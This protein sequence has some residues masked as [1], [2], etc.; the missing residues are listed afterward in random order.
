MPH[1]AIV[2]GTRKVLHFYER[3]DVTMLF[4]LSADQGEVENI[5][6]ERPNEHKKLHNEMMGYFKQ[7][8]ARIP[9]VNPDYDPEFYQQT[10]EYAQRMA[11][12]P[13]EGR[14]ALDDDEL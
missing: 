11:W 8:D 2:S 9:K 10:K 12:G 7:V 14:R 5:A 4:D 6:T 1:S 3:P 13:F